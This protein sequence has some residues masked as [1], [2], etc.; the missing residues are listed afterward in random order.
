MVEVV[1]LIDQWLADEVGDESRTV[2][3]AHE[4]VDE[5]EEQLHEDVPDEH[6]HSD[7]VVD[8]DIDMHEDEVEE[9]EQLDVTLQFV[10][11]ELTDEMGN[12]AVLVETVFDIREDDEGDD[13]IVILLVMVQADREVDADFYDATAMGVEEVDDRQQT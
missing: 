1:A 8:V 3:D 7:M 12:V 2:N 10:N 6:E 9:H 4:Q 5:V 13:I 11:V